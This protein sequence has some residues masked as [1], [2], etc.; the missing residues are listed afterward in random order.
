MTKTQTLPNDSP[1]WDQAA[2]ML[3][4]QATLAE[5]MSTVFQSKPTSGLYKDEQP[6][7]PNFGLFVRHVRKTLALSPRTVLR[8]ALNQALERIL[9]SHSAAILELSSLL[10]IIAN[11]IHMHPLAKAVSLASPGLCHARLVHARKELQQHQAINP[12]DTCAKVQAKLAKNKTPQEMETILQSVRQRHNQRALYLQERVQTLQ[13]ALATDKEY[14]KY[15]RI[16]QLW[17]ITGCQKLWDRFLKV[18]RQQCQLRNHEG[19]SFESS[20][21]ELVFAMTVLCLLA[22]DNID[23]AANKEEFSF[24]CNLHWWDG[25]NSNNKVPSGEIDLAVFHKEKVVAIC[26][27]KSS[28][29]LLGQA[30]RQHE[31]KIA[32][33]SKQST[34]AMGI[35]KTPGCLF[36]ISSACPRLFVATTAPKHGL[37]GAEPVLSTAIGDGIRH[38][39]LTI[40]NETTKAASAPLVDF[41]LEEDDDDATMTTNAV[42]QY[43]WSV[44]SPKDA[45]EV[46]CSS[47]C[48]EEDCLDVAQLAEFVKGR[49][50]DTLGGSLSP[51]GCLLKWKRNILILD[52]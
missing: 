20:Q 24:A 25:S 6:T 21:Q 30:F 5:H 38:Q 33:M 40:A 52:S 10:E 45:A 49:L 22:N 29:F 34:L 12:E 11:P 43:L 44:F 47:K 2:A 7:L 50:G 8:S 46:N 19:D 35:G 51:A 26:E 9:Q 3:Q 42:I 16:Q 14:Q 13:I 28:C 39:G 1:I 15:C 31:Q 48:G 36:S 37:L 32:T 18:D 17:E 27:M 41:L 23:L 4:T